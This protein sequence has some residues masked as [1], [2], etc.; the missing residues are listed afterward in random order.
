MSRR[1]PVRQAL[2]ALAGLAA[3]VAA[4]LAAPSPASAAALPFGRATYVVSTMEGTPKALAVRLATYAFATDGTVTERY[5]AWRQDAVHNGLNT[6][7]T[8]V[9]S[10]YTTAGC[11]RACPV[12]TPY[13]FQRGAAPRTFR[14]RWSMADGGVLVIRWTATLVE[15]W[16]LDDGQPDVVGARLVTGNG[17]I[18]WGVGSNAPA[19]RGVSLASIYG[20]GGWITG[21]FAENVYAPTTAHAAIGFGTAD[22]S[23]CS[24]GRCLQGRGMTAPDRSTWYHSYFAA[25]PAVDGRKVYWNNQTGVVQHYEDPS[26]VCISASGGGHTNALLEALDDAG[27][28]VGF[29]GV[30]A[31]LGQPKYGQDVVAAYTMLTPSLLPSI[32]ASTGASTGG[33]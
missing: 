31:S 9:P 10:G 8:K 23:L 26:G 7:W 32:G 29:V 3:A 15:R 1:R 27:R 2:G 14:G 24:T 30:E 16:Q 20:A 18:G 12:R 11:L 6:R 33:S 21:P 13:G 5:W 25:D 28:F 17:S 19:G 22:Y 4:Q